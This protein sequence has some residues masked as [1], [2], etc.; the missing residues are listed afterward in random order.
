MF[1]VHKCEVQG[2]VEPVLLVNVG[3]SG[4]FNFNSHFMKCRGKD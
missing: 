1:Y 4:V 2:D 3:V